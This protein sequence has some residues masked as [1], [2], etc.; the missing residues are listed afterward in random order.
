MKSRRPV[1][2]DVMWLR[3]SLL[4]VLGTAL[5]ASTAAAVPRM[6]LSD[7][8]RAAIIGSVARDLFKP[9]HNYE[10]KH[11]ILFNGIRPEWLPKL[12]GYDVRLLSQEEIDSARVPIYYYALW[13]RPQKHSVRVTVH[14]YDSETKTLPH[15]MLF[16]LYYRVEHGWRGL[17]RG[18]GGD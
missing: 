7:R 2:S 3:L 16:Y 4:V 5:G 6:K 12:P 9:G 17:P 11:F 10:G 8:D 1:N 14:L 13:L 18:G 15:V